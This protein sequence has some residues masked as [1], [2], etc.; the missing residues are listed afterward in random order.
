MNEEVRIGILVVLFFIAV[1]GGTAVILNIGSLGVGYTI[2]SSVYTTLERTVIPVPVPLTSPVLYPGQISNYS[3]YGYGIWAYGDGLGYEKRLDLM[4]GG[5][6][7][8]SASHSARLLNFFT[9][10]DIHIADKET[11]AQAIVFGYKGGNPSAYSPTALMT[12][13]T[14]DAAVQTINALHKKKPFDFGIALGDAIN[15]NQYNELRWYIDVFDGKTINPDSGA[16][17]DPVFGPLNDY[18][19]IYKAAGL[20]KTIPWYQTLGNHDQFWLGTNVPDNYLKQTLI[21]RNILNL[22]DSITDPLGL[23]S[24]GF[25]MGS[26]DGRTMYGDV[27]GAG[28]VSEFNESPQVPAADPDRRALSR[29]EWMAE[30]FNSSTGPRGHGF[31]SSNVPAGFACYSFEPKPDIPIRVIVLDDTQ[32]DTDANVS[33]FMYGSLDKARYDWLVNEL[34]RGQA[35]GKLMIIAA[36]I[37]IRN[38][39]AV[40]SKLWTP[41]SPVSEQM[42]IA[43]LHTYPNLVLWISGHVHRNTVTAFKSPDPVHPELG[44]WEVETA[45]LRDFPQQFRTFEIIRNSDNTVSV[46]AADVDPDVS[47]RSPAAISRSYAVATMQ[48]FNTTLVPGPSGSYNAELVKQLSPEM[49]VKIQN[50]GTSLN[51]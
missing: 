38:E 24:R 26:I 6:P 41:A 14:L 8:T 50:T 2:N 43:K 42:L 20:N 13:Q 22:G 48:V 15:N 51:G 19:D 35:E 27:T 47:D 31:N 45:S 25:Y 36:H 44:F 37:P 34:D 16:K 9:M 7:G 40:S 49:Q 12:T 10:S 39:S 1:T 11:P 30:F 46:F 28:P 17:D 4:P 3:E 21:G 18:Q 5:Y 33:L 32:R 29:S 23:A